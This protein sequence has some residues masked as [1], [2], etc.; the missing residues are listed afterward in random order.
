M[1]SHRTILGRSIR[2]EWIKL[3]S[4]RAA[5]WSTLALLA[6]TVALS[7]LVCSALTTAGGGPT[8]PGTGGDEDV[9]RNSLT[10]V[11]LGQLGVVAL[12]V[13]AAT[14]EFATGTIRV[15]FLAMPR[16]PRVLLAK[17]CVVGALMLAAGLVASASSFLVGQPILHGNGF[18]CENG[19][20]IV[21]LADTAAMRAVLGTA[22]YLTLVAL[23]GLAVGT[24][25]RHTAAAI[26]TV[27]ALL[28]LPFMVALMLPEDLRATV[29]QI[30]PMTAGL[31]VQQTVER[32]DNV[33]IAPWAGLGVTA[34]W[35]I[36][37]LVVG[38][39][40]IARRDS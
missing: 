17:A 16:R 21:T 7:A 37:A 15:T 13:L 18:T 33:P 34:A 19:Y 40:L 20:L 11:Y 35:T 39:L 10:G 12:G 30:S 1:S 8:C 5:S 29:Q 36:A 14:S 26:T 23:L 24:I 32:F 9:I 31:A 4:V 27:V 6:G 3:R 38:A 2:A 25:L 22:V 28:Y